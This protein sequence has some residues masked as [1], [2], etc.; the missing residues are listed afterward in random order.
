MEAKGRRHWAGQATKEEEV[1]DSSCTQGKSS[2]RGKYTNLSPLLRAYKA[3]R[4]TALRPGCSSWTLSAPWG[5]EAMGWEEVALLWRMVG[6]EPGGHWQSVPVA[7]FEPEVPSAQSCL[8]AF[9]ANI[10][11]QSVFSGG[12]PYGRHQELLQLCFCTSP[13]RWFLWLF[14]QH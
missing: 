9:M 5:R 14:C 2:A 7:E 12:L 8:T 11:P 3:V 1:L 10:I 13:A 6:V 4:N